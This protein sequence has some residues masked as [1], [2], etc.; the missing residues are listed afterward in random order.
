MKLIVPA[1]L[2]TIASAHAPRIAHAQQ[3]DAT[4]F[5]QRASASRVKGQSTA[6][7]LV[8]E[9][10]DFQCPFCAKFL[11]I[12]AKL[13]SAFIK[14]GKVQWV[15]VNLPL[16]IHPHAWAAAEAAMCA[17]AVAKK[18]WAL[19]DRLFG[20]QHE[21]SGTGDPSALLARYA[22]EAGV[23]ADAYQACVTQDKVAAI[24]LEDAMFAARAEVSGTP[25]F[26]INGDHRIVGVKTFEE[27][28][29]VIA[30]AM[31][32]PRTTR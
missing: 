30:L 5:S 32:K 21:W 6:P 20:A 2:L 12:H 3:T 14:T 18:F 28:S 29:D 24:V 10:A 8:Y 9:I 16:P 4:S 25:T 1:L 22:R 11:P 19:H 27:W 17:G 7:V 15:Y 26:I 23:P 13:D 31:Q